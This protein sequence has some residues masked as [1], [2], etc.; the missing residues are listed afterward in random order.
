MLSVFVGIEKQR[1]NSEILFT[2]GQQSAEMVPR[3]RFTALFEG[4]FLI[5]VSMPAA[6]NL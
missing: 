4:P 2:I 5:I 6:A 1:E 3:G